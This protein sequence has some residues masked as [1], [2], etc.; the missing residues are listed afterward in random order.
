LRSDTEELVKQERT[1][2]Q[3]EREKFDYGFEGAMAE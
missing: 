1:Q 2:R 3:L